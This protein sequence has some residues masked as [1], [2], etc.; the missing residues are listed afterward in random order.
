MKIVN[1]SGGFGGGG[2]GGGGGGIGGGGFGGGVSGGKGGGGEI[3]GTGHGTTLNVFSPGSEGAGKVS[4]VGIKQRV[5]VYSRIWE[6]LADRFER[7]LAKNR[8]HLV[9]FIIGKA[10]FEVVKEHVQPELEYLHPRSA[11]YVDFF[12]IGFSATEKSDPTEYNETLNTFEANS[13]WRRGGG[14]DLILVN[15]VYDPA[16]KRVTPNFAQALA[17]SLENVKKVDGFE[18][19]AVFFERIVSAAKKDCGVESPAGVSDALGASLIK[20]ATKGLLASV[21]PDG[22]KEETKAAFLFAVKDISKKH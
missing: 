22:M 6:I 18:N 17:L 7:D 3:G 9:G 13:E 12:T 19:L 5:P 10:H 4:S 8:P 15:V 21:V 16:T 20:S 1:M 14:T 11:Q 2:F